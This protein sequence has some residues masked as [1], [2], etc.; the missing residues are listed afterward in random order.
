[1]VNGQRVVARTGGVGTYNGGGHAEQAVVPVDEVFAIPDRVETSAALAALHDGATA[2][3]Q[4][5]RA[6]AV[7]GERVLL[8]V[9]TGSL[10]NWLVPLLSATG[11]KV[12]AAARGEEKLRRAKELGADEVV[13]YSAPDWADALGAVDVVF[14]ATGGAIGRAA[15]GATAAGQGEHS[16][17]PSM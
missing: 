13:D 15:Y 7:A 1:V 6:K 9:A 8:T 16:A 4:L 12:V 11:V 14:D 17:V 3:A 5:E 10:G 2:L